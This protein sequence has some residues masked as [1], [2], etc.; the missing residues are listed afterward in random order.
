MT[1]Q[2]LSTEIKAMTTTTP[3]NFDTLSAMKFAWLATISGKAPTTKKTYER[4]MSV[5]FRWLEDNLVKSLD[6][7][8]LTDFNNFAKTKSNATA[9]LYSIVTKKFCRYACQKLR[10]ED[11]TALVEGVKPDNEEYHKRAAVDREDGKRVLKSAN[12]DKEIESLRVETVKIVVES[13]KLD[14]SRG[15]E[16]RAGDFFRRD[17]RAYLK[18]WQGKKFETI[19][20]TADARNAVANFYKERF[21]F[22]RQMVLVNLLAVL[23]LR[24]IE[25]ARL[26]ANGKNGGIFQRGKIFFLKI[27]GKARTGYSDI[28]ILPPKTKAVLERYLEYRA[29]FKAKYD[30]ETQGEPMFIS[31]CKRNFGGRIDVSVVAKAAKSALVSAGLGDGYSPHS[32]RHGAACLYLQSENSN[33]NNL[34]QM[35]R[36]KSL[37]T[38][39]RYV[40]SLNFWN[41]DA[42]LVI[43]RQLTT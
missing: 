20:L 1:T 43:E 34:R 29:D 42:T 30:E 35:L 17:H 36:H 13:C 2:A 21:V 3:I 23:G 24:T 32:L 22:I 8:V 10:I 39:T 37:A 27:K 5:F 25:V 38:S 33:V 11:F 14:S 31:L 19:T 12:H 6:E 4:V 9:R 40:A 18:I 26:N 28:A 7:S 41:N 15:I 16:F